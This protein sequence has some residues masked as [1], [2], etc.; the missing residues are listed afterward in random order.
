MRNKFYTLAAL[1]ITTL[2]IQA[3]TPAMVKDINSGSGGSN[4]TSLVDVN[5]TLFFRASDG[6]NGNELWKSNGTDAGTVMVKNIKYM[7]SKLSIEGMDAYKKMFLDL[8]KVIRFK[9]RGG[10][11]KQSSSVE[12]I[13]VGEGRARLYQ[14]LVKLPLQQ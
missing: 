9:S 10:L 3:Q 4:T 11:V 6:T 5:G 7:D 12:N 14:D 2:A 13:A 1:L 8:G